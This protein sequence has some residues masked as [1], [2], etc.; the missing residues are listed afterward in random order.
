MVVDLK[1]V[2]QH[3]RSMQ[4]LRSSVVLLVSLMLIFVSAAVIRPDLDRVKDTLNKCFD[5]IEDS[6]GHSMEWK[7]R[8]TQ[9]QGEQMVMQMYLNAVAD[10]ED[11]FVGDEDTVAFAEG[12]WLKWLYVYIDTGSYCGEQKPYSDLLGMCITKGEG[13]N[14]WEALEG[15]YD[16]WKNY[17]QPNG[18]YYYKLFDGESSRDDL[19]A[20][21]DALSEDLDNL[22]LISPVMTFQVMLSDGYREYVTAFWETSVSITQLKWIDA[23]MPPLYRAS[24][25]H[26]TYPMLV[27]NG[28]TDD[29]TAETMAFQVLVLIFAVWRFVDEVHEMQV[30][31]HTTG[32]MGPYFCSTWNIIDLFSILFSF[33][34]TIAAMVLGDLTRSRVSEYITESDFMVDPYILSTQV[35]LYGNYLTSMFLA[36][37]V[38]ALVTSVSIFKYFRELHPG[39]ALFSETMSK[40]QR[41]LVNVVIVVIY[42]MVAI[43]LTV[44]LVFSW[45]GANSNFETFGSTFLSILNLCLGFYDY[46]QFT[47]GREYAWT[48]LVVFMSILFVITVFGLVIIS[49]NLI[50]AVIAE[51]YADAKVMLEGELDTFPVLIYYNIEMTCFVVWVGILLCTKCMFNVRK[52]AEE[53]LDSRWLHKWKWWRRGAVTLFPEAATV[54]ASIEIAS[55]DED[56]AGFGWSSDPAAA[57][58]RM[59]KT[60]AEAKETDDDHVASAALGAH[61]VASLTRELTR[62]EVKELITELAESGAIYKLKWLVFLPFRRF[63]W[64]SPEDRDVVLDRYLDALF[65]A[66]GKPRAAD[67]L[68]LSGRL[69]L[70]GAPS[71]GGMPQKITRIFGKT[72]GGGVTHAAGGATSPSGAA[73]P[74]QPAG[75]AGEEWSLG[76]GVAIEGTSSG[77]SG[78]SGGSPFASMQQP[79]SNAQ[80]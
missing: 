44:W 79:R 16:K 77:A 73:V 50:L 70:A 74:P 15:T 76:A 9:K 30:S 60:A 8:I 20:N 57:L 40:A 49:Q 53:V 5:D 69:A 32:S 41:P 58:A 33:G 24:I 80:L 4:A 43:S 10:S 42:I 13:I 67:D 51:A 66:F 64:P 78:Q 63:Y 75:G 25:G 2:V 71:G 37:V 68:F 26:T 52:A 22:N 29:N 54:L 11:R 38:V 14:V 61:L 46:E 34:L 7:T 21:L 28:G 35:I 27:A 12:I 19:Q 72:K 31:Y 1:Q 6:V 59:R 55:G 56:I 65:K 45:L 48:V 18:Y 47:G 23:S 62:A 3:A 39:L 36:L 17:G